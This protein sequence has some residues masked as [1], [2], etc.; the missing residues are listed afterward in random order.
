M[1]VKD[2][3]ASALNLLG[4][5]DLVSALTSGYFDDEGR[6][7]INTLL[8][9]FNAV[10][11]ELARK[12]IPL[13]AKEEMVSATMRYYYSTFQHIPVKIKKV[14]ADGVELKFEIYSLYMLT[15]AKIIVTEYEY[16]PT[17]KK[18]DGDSDFGD[19]VGEYLLALGIAAEYSFING[20]AEM[21]A[22]W[23]KKYRARLDSIQHALPACEKI[24]PRRWI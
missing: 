13:T 17:R 5:A 16:A 18:L 1:K 12:Y 6:E 9:C 19:E 10:E 4:R 22:Q 24:P 15:S 8:Y 2:V 20:E 11:D 3:I 14:T 7:L 21:A 23:E